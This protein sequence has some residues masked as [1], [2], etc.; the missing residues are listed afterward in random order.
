M[1]YDGSVGRPNLGK[2][3][4]DLATSGVLRRGVKGTGFLSEGEEYDAVLVEP[5][6]DVKV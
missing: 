3:Y 2:L 4:R 1:W 5:S 6:L